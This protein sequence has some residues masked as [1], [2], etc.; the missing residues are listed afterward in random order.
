[1]ARDYK[2]IDTTVITEV[3]DI[4]S[5]TTGI[6]MVLVRPELDTKKIGEQ[7]IIRDTYFEEINCSS[8][9]VTV[10]K[11]PESLAIKGQNAY[12]DRHYEALDW[13]TIM[14]LQEGDLA[15][16]DPLHMLNNNN[17]NDTHVYSCKGH[18]YYLIRYDKF[19]AVKR[20]DSKIM[21]NGYVLLEKIFK[22]RSEIII[23]VEPENKTCKVA[24]VGTPNKYYF[25][26]FYS[27]DLH[28]KVGDIVSNPKY[29][30][31]FEGDLYRNF[32]KGKEYFLTQ[33]RSIPL[34]YRDMNL[35]ESLVPPGKM[36]VT[37]KMKEETSKS[38][39]IIP[40][41]IADEEKLGVVVKIGDFR[42]D[43]IMSGL[44]V[45]ST[46]SYSRHRNEV[47]VDG[48]SYLYLDVLDVLIYTDV[49]GNSV[50]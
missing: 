46:V 1:M 10:I 45:G 15:W 40:K 13:F 9:E 4:A 27:D 43:E 38:G 28:T 11:T 18:L 7:G 31:P 35:K 41:S 16:V 20:G 33:R 19:F 34:I 30:I 24:Y 23:D 50:D 22:N 14:E 32:D 25:N 29:L 21:L 6:N 8:R 17:T 42:P 39:I 44:G 47:M 3:N 48:I 5:I 2:Y 26:G 49:D 12:D 36:L 37:K